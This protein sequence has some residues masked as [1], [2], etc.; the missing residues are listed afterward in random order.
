MKKPSPANAKISLPPRR[1]PILEEFLALSRILTGVEKLDAELGRQYL[2]RLN[3]GPFSV[4]FGQIVSRFQGLKNKADLAGQVKKRIVSDDSLR[5]TV[6]Q[7]ILLWYTSTL[8]ENLGVQPP[9]PPVMRFGTQEE[10]FSGLAWTI[11]GAHPPGLS[12]GYF[13]HWR[14]R[15]ENEPKESK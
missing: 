9:A 1:A 4:P 13:G 2:D 3:S 5:P 8:Q 15:P 11:I 10:Y 6:C 12:G 7:I 14:Y